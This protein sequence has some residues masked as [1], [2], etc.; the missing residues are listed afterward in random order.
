MTAIDIKVSNFPELA[1]CQCLV[2]FR[3]SVCISA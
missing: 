1:A 2:M 3:K